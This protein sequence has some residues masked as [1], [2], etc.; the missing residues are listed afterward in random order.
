MKLTGRVS[1]ESVV[2]FDCSDVTFVSIVG[3]LERTPNDEVALDGL[4]D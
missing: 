4:A 2:V 1:A 3:R